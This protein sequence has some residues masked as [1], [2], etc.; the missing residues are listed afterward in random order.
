M[1]LSLLI[2]VADEIGGEHLE[3]HIATQLRVVRPIDLTHAA[4]ADPF[5]DRVGADAASTERHA[6]GAAR[7]RAAH[8]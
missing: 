3:R 2:V 7:T 6:V 8:L 1:I 4:R 5:V